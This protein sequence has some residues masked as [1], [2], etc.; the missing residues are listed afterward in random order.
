MDLRKFAR[1]GVGH[2]DGLHG[3]KVWMLHPSKATLEQS[4]SREGGPVAGM[5]RG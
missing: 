5:G 1:K 3:E 2:W 4:C